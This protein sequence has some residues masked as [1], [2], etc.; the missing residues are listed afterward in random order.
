MPSR[1]IPELAID[2]ESKMKCLITEPV[3]S[4]LSLSMSYWDSPQKRLSNTIKLYEKAKEIREPAE[5][6]LIESGL[7]LTRK[8][9]EGACNHV[10][11][12][13]GNIDI[14]YSV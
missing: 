11:R 5:K 8:T 6:S 1:I 13:V 14:P 2:R 4:L 3:I 9:K 7:I 10:P 12:G